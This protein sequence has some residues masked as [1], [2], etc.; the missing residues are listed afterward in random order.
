MQKGHIFRLHGAWH[1]R[2]RANGEQV[3][4]K[5][6][7][8]TDQYRTKT[9]VRPLAERYLQPVNQGFA[10]DPQTVQQFI[11]LVYLPHA[12]LHKRPSTVKGY[13]NLYKRYVQSHVA[14]IRLFGFRTRDGQNL[15]NRVAS[16]HALSHL[17]LIHVKSF[18]S[19]VFTQAKRVGSLDTGN[20]M[21]GVEVPKGKESDPTHAYSK[22]EVDKMLSVLQ[23]MPQVAVTVAAYTG[24]SLGELQGLQW[25][26]VAQDQLNVQR[27]IWHGIEGMPKTK[28]RKDSIPLLPIVR[29]ALKQHR[30]ANP[31]TKWI[32]EG[33]YVRPLDLATLGSKGIKTALKGSG[34]Q[35]YGW[36]ALRR[37]FATRL[38]EAGVQDR[39]IQ[40]LMRH[41]SLSVTMKHYV[42]ATPEA[43]VEA[44]QR[45]NPKKKRR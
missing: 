31:S 25:L 37:G 43:N 28:A 10:S 19:G 27:T 21:Q 33:P 4:V 5:L 42:K 1:L 16:E 3:S 26:D 36:H 22:V 32:F 24:L 39:I 12:E 23:G 17:T 35:W 7:D 14:G 44:M 45:L 18:L 13:R 8:Y 40:A 9:S 6:T 34:V 30:K 38:H 20:P 11:D 29:T 15:L 2:Y 41:S